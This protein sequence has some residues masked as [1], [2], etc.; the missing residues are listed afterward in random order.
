[1]QRLNFFRKTVNS[2]GFSLFEVLVVASIT[3]FI[4]V[5]LI[6]S[7]SS[8][9]SVNLNRVANILA[10]DIR[11]AQ[12]LTLA[13]H[14][15]K[16]PLDTTPR[17]RCGYGISN[18]G[19]GVSSYV[20]YAG[21]PTVNSAGAPQNCPSNRNFDPTQPGDTPIY[22]ITHLDQRVDFVS[23]PAFGD[24]FFEP[25]RPIVYIDNDSS[26]PVEK[27]IIKKKSTTLDDCDSGSADCI[28]VCVYLSSRV[29]VTK[30]LNCPA[31]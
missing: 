1:M 8:L 21:L 14:L 16:G 13:S 3:I 5:S 20:L 18:S 9:S 6:Y 23:A 17:I 15:F 4:S 19:Q 29:E 7:L 24:I 12:Q 30:N 2:K 31:I 27:I 25:P 10:S 22:Q 11:L 26:S 28:Y